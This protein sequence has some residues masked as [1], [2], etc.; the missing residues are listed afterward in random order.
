VCV[1]EHGYIRLS[2]TADSQTFK[3][4]RPADGVAC[5]P[6]PKSQTVGGECGV[7]F[8]TSYPTGVAAAAA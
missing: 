6:V 1:P 8:D 2:R 7:L 4:K 3:D 5:E